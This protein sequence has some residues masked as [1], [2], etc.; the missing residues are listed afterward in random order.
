MHTAKVVQE[1]CF[2]G[3]AKLCWVVVGI[4]AAEPSTVYKS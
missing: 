1:L 4:L 2:D 3:C